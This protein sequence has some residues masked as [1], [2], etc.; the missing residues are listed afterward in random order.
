M[1]YGLTILGV[2]YSGLVRHES[3]VDNLEA[4]MVDESVWSRCVA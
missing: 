4:A 2:R 3:C 1:A